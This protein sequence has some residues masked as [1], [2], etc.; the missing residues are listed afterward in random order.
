MTTT[1]LMRLPQA[2][3]RQSPLHRQLLSCRA[4][5]AESALGLMPAR[6]GDLAT[7][8][9]QA[10]Q[11]GLVDLCLTPRAGFKGPGAAHFLQ[12]HSVALPGSPNRTQQQDNGLLVNQLSFDEYLLLD[13][14]ATAS[15][16]ITTLC[17]AWSLDNAPDCY[18]VPRQDSHGCLAVTGQAAWRMLSSLISVDLR[19]HRFTDFQ[20]AQTLLND[21]SVIVIRC[22]QGKVP[23]YYLLADITSME[24]LWIVLLDAM[25][26]AGGGPIGLTTFQALQGSID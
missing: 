2:L 17:N 6:Y 1:D 5:L 25:S 16:M 26:D 22:D 9:A 24:W 11:L 13:T 14:T 12:Q 15:T 20:I 19:P 21:L 18:Q 7:D 23:N 8:T 3:A 10:D 4:S